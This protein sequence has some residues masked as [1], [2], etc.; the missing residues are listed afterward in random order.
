MSKHPIYTAEQWRTMINML[1][2]GSVE[3]CSR[4]YDIRSA[5]F[6]V[7]AVTDTRGRDPS[8][9]FSEGHIT[10]V[11]VQVPRRPTGHCYREG[12]SL[13]LYAEPNKLTQVLICRASVILDPKMKKH[14]VFYFHIRRGATMHEFPSETY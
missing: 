9:P 3:K 5:D 11:V 2:L 14:I 6:N 10:R 7:V 1:P 12:H 4:D 13:S 8:R